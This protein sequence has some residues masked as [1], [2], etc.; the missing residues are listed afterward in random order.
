MINMFSSNDMYLSFCI[1][2]SCPGPA[3]CILGVG[4]FPV[5]SQGSLTIFL[6]PLDVGKLA[7]SQAKFLHTC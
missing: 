1:L 2:M 7:I 5:H 3:V 4:S 6:V